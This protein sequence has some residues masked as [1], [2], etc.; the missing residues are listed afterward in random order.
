[1]CPVRTNDNWIPSP[2]FFISVA[3]KGLSAFVSGLES[4]L[5]GISISVDSKWVRDETI[6]HWSED[7]LGDAEQIRCQSQAGECAAPR[8]IGELGRGQ[9]AA[10][11]PVVGLG[12]VGERDPEAVPV[13]GRGGGNRSSGGRDCG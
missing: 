9:C 7:C 12:M 3:S 13:T 4:T 1:M 8:P 5:A 2:L 6:P 11:G 10:M